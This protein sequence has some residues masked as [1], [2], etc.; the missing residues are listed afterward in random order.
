MKHSEVVRA[1]V[2]ASIF[3]TELDRGDARAP[4]RAATKKGGIDPPF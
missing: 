1:R 2:Y 3:Y 4:M